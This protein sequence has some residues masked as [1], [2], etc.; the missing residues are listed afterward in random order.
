MPPLLGESP[1]PRKTPML[2]RLSGLTMAGQVEVDFLLSSIPTIQE[3]A[4]E[5]GFAV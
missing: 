3:Q 5:F 1:S 2:Y 4:H